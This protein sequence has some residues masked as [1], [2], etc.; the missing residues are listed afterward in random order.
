MTLPL[1]SSAINKDQKTWET[2]SAGKVALVT[3]ASKGIGAGI[4]TAFGVAGAKVA[5]GYARDQEGAERVAAE[6]KAAGGQAIT[7]QADLAKTA[8]IEA[9]VAKAVATF[10]PDRY[11]GQQRRRV[12]LQTVAGHR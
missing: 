8:D 1:S 4:A 9:M 7:V 10:G 6:I 2:S 12:R 11:P 5:V 3:G